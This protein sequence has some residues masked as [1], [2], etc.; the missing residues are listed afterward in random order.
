MAIDDDGYGAREGQTPIDRLVEDCRT[1]SPAG[2]ERIAH[3]WD[4]LAGGERHA[5][6]HEAER[7]ALAVLEQSGRAP[8]WD[9]L[10]NRLLGLTEVGTPM[11]AWRIEHGETGHKAEGALLGAALALVAGPDLDRPHREVLLRPM[12]EA[13]P[14]LLGGNLLVERGRPIA[15]GGTGG[16]SRGRMG[17]RAAW[18]LPPA[19]R[20]QEAADE[21]GDA[22]RAHRPGGQRRVPAGDASGRR[23]AARRPPPARRLPA[24]RGGPRG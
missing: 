4:G 7:A 3:G 16:F 12:A 24:H 6:Y 14:W 13:L 19:S 15:G 18:L 8:R 22:G 11:I 17:P 5:A 10:R 1:L 9:E 23:R 20:S 2:I 21:H